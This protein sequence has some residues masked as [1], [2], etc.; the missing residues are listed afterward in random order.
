MPKISL[1][2]CLYKERDLLER[3]LKHA[4]GCYDDLVVVHDGK[5][6]SAVEW[7]P[8][9]P[10]SELAIDW[11]AYPPNSLPPSAFL[12]NQTPE[13]PGS[14]REFVRLQGGRFY[15]HPRVGSLEGQSPFG[16]WM[17]EHDWIL[18]LDADEFPSQEL[19]S[20]LVD[21]R[22]Q[23]SPGVEISGFMCIWPYWNG[24]AATTKNWPRDRIF[25]FHRE[26]VRFFGMVEQV[27]IP[28]TLLEPLPLI[29]HHEPHG[30]RYGIRKT[31]FRK[32]AGN[33]RRVIASSLLGTPLDLPRWRWNSR[34]WPIGWEKVRSQPLKEAFCRILLMPLHQ[35]RSLMRA[36]NIPWPS[37]CLGSA[38]HHF[39]F[40]LSYLTRRRKARKGNL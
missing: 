27:P 4:D 20:F 9:P 30:K 34:C 32:H 16:W 1:V 22:N 10:G 36:G 15:E 14:L 23:S 24:C 17:A 3:L 7:K 21:F 18:R 40:C 37:I 26:R 25:L 11:A 19:C 28:D 12:E 8:G 35:A 29:L 39:L 31:L 33:W 2:V 13:T 5:E 38:I 6:S